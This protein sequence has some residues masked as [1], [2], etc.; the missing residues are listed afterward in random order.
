[1][2]AGDF[3]WL[4]KV[5]QVFMVSMHKDRPVSAQEEGAATLE[6]KDDSCKFFV[7]SVIVSLG[8]LETSG[9]ECYR[10]DSIIELL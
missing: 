7:M 4:S 2:A 1:L 5:L 9:V 10:V 3:L 8:F 6:T